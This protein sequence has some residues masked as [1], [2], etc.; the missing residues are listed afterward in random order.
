DAKA[1]TARNARVRR[2]LKIKAAPHA[3]TETEI[4]EEEIQG[5]FAQNEEGGEIQIG[6]KRGNTKAGKNATTRYGRACYRVR[7]RNSSAQDIG[8]A[9]PTAFAPTKEPQAH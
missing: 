1:D 8:G 9:G 2:F 3:Y 5:G 6:A 4:R 7:G